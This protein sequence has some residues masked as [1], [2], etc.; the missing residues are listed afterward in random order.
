MNAAIA[1]T[2]QLT[3]ALNKVVLGRADTVKAV[4]TS[5]IAGGH[6]L[7]EDY[8]GSGKTT[9]ARTLGRLI[10][11]PN[12]FADHLSMFKRI[13]FTPDMLPSDVLG[14]TIFEPNTATFR[15]SPGPV[16]AHIVLADELNRTGPKVQAA[17]LE[18]MAEKQVTIEGV[19]KRLDP[20]FFV[21][22]T[23]N[24]LD[25]AGTYPLPMVQ[26]DRFM[27]RV[28]M[29]YVDSSTE[30]EILKKAAQISIDSYAIKPIISFD[31]IIAAQQAI[32]NVMIKEPIQR[33]IVDLVQ[34]TRR[35]SSLALGAST[36]AAVLL[37]QALK[38]YAIVHGREF[39]I[40]DDLKE[41]A[42]LVLMHRLK[43]HGSSN[44]QKVSFQRLLDGVI[45]QLVRGEYSR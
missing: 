4:V 14:V 25:I 12:S 33:A 21:I 22:A 40:E 24:P 31:E 37:Q 27:I 45:E 5:L 42:P 15:F 39:V 34:R 6:V 10:A 13:Q 41:L 43:F 26:L 7:I 17:F 3:E 44:E 35:D 2:A 30:L 36:R 8:P 20:L 29:N 32:A 1:T 19:T 38:G 18:C 16:F 28:P 11:P 23:Q 9:L